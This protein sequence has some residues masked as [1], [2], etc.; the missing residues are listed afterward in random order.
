MRREYFDNSAASDDL[1]GRSL[2][3]GVVSMVAQGANMALQI[4]STIVLARLLMP[5]DFGLVAMVTAITG[6][7][8]VFVDLGTRDALSQR[9]RVTEGEVSALFWINAAVGSILT[10]ATIGVAPVIAGFYGESRLVWVAVALSLTFL[11]PSLHYQQYAL[12]RRALMFGRLAIIDVTA[13]LLATAMAIVLA[14]EGFG[15]W[16]LVFKPVATMLFS[17]LGVWVACGWLP[18]RPA[19]TSE[20][21]SI[22][23]FGLNVTGFTMADY[24]SRSI[25]RV[26]LGYTTGAR[27]LGYYQNAFVVYENPLSLFTVPLHSVAVSTLSKLRN[28]LPELRRAWATA[29]SSLVFFAAPAFALLAVTGQDVVVLLLGQKWEQAGV[30]VSV[31]ALRGPPHV[32]ERTL[33]WLHVAAGRAD[34]WRRWGLLSCGVLVLAVFCGLPFGPIGVAAS[35]AAFTYVLFVPAIVYAGK[36]LGI[37]AR[38]VVKTV[39]PQLAA[40]VGITILGFVLRYTVFADVEPL[41]RVIVLCAICATTYLVV[42]VFGFGMNRPLELVMR[43]I[44]RRIGLG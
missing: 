32:V 6:F 23:R 28:D 29:L 39:G 17:T 5:E 31:L 40:T 27:Q 30:I 26:A 22:L 4:V 13:N 44:R 42:M 37:G 10:V 21:W 36:P 41:M 19:F 14:L 15:Y 11:L 16:A 38:D 24:V 1:R 34:R 2:R 35:Y 8:T 33:G 12:M 3:S 43:P 25:D 18:G 20:V 9:E 7:A